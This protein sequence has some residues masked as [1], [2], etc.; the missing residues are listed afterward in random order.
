MADTFATLLDSWDQRA[1]RS[2]A[3]RHWPGADPVLPRLS[4]AAN[5]GLLWF[6]AAA[7]IA[8]LGRGA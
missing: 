8:V 7:G 4:R 3:G 5:H 2:V 6:G 1:F